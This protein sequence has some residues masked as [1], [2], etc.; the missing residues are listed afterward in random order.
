MKRIL[1]PVD[2]SST[3]ENALNYAIEF[4]AT[5]GGKLTLLHTYEVVNSTGAFMSVES[6][7]K[8]DA[9]RQV[10]SFAK[11]VEQKLGSSNVDTK[12]IKGDFLSVTT[13]LS[14][15]LDYDLLIMGTEG[16]NNLLENLLG[17]HTSEVVS[18]IDRTIIV[19]PDEFEYR[20]IKN[21][22]LA[23]DQHNVVLTTILKPLLEVAKAYDAMVRVY[24]IDTG[25]EDTGIDVKIESGLD[26]V[27]HSFHYELNGGDLSENI[28]QF[29][30][31]YQAELLC[32]IRRNRSF[33][34]QLFHSSTTRKEV[35]HSTTPLLILKD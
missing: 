32:L 14:K 29:V 34:E 13:N 26:Q 3:A 15:Q 23:A 8:S 21:I 17:T 4:A 30:E 5:V 27:N 7:I 9:A 10:L 25:E 33:W 31:D 35:L 2:F 16:A 24:H 28:D 22:V 18:K 6:Y 1:V 12:I 20:P 11:K 19:V